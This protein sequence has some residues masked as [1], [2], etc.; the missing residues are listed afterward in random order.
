MPYWHPLESSLQ[1]VTQA[2]QRMIFKRLLK[3][4]LHCHFMISLVIHRQPFIEPCRCID[5]ILTTK[6]MKQQM[7]KFMG[8]VAY[9]GNVSRILD[10]DGSLIKFGKGDATDP[11][12]CTWRERA[13]KIAGC[14]INPEIDWD[15]ADYLRGCQRCG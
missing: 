6:L 12:V 15:L 2:Q 8:H 7:C 1:I 11:F 9:Q 5:T 10:N 3:G 13:M 4:L 14:L